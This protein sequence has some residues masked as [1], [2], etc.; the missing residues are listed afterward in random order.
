MAVI[1]NGKTLNPA[2]RETPLIINGDMKVSQ[3]DTSTTGI[4]ADTAFVVD[5]F[6]EF[7]SFY[8]LI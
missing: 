6:K 5:R 2:S 8:E 3:R 7:N 1:S 4:G